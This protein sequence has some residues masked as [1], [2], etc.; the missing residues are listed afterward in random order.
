MS[1][2]Y[3]QTTL[4]TMNVIAYKTSEARDKSILQSQNYDIWVLVI[5]LI[6]GLLILIK[7]QIIE[8]EVRKFLDFEV[9]NVK[10]EKP[11]K[12]NNT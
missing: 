7:K 8:V 5:D 4:I 12:R 11:H 9:D 1:S 2:R 3:L 10:L 6:I